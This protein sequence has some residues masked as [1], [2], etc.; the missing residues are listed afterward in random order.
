MRPTKLV[1]GEH[2]VLVSDWTRALEKEV[3]H[4][5]LLEPRGRPMFDGVGEAVMLAVSV[6]LASYPGRRRGFTKP[7]RRQGAPLCP[8]H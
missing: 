5:R 6:L 4:V 2:P 7:P 3:C 8:G 1:A